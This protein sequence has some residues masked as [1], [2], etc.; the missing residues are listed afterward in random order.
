M[1]D[2]GYATDTGCTRPRSLFRPVQG[3]PQAV[4]ANVYGD[5]T[6]FNC[7]GH[8]SEVITRI[9][10]KSQWQESVARVNRKSQ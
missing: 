9:N 6:T 3:V 5:E 4:M 1:L 10:K 2:F 7:F 8:S